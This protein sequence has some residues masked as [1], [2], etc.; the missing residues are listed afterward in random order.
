MAGGQVGP[1]SFL[2]MFGQGEMSRTEVWR[3]AEN[4][5]EQCKTVRCVAVA[6]ERLGESDLQLQIVRLTLDGVGEHLDILEA[7]D[8]GQDSLGFLV[9]V[10]LA[11]REAELVARG[12]LRIGSSLKTLRSRGM[13]RTERPISS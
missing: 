2:V 3:L 13:A 10:H 5:L 1:A 7:L 12:A 8:L 11:E 6:Q 4:R 9:L